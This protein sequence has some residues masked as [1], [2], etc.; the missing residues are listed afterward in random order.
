MAIQ[1][2][3]FGADNLTSKEYLHCPNMNKL[4]PIKLLL[5][6]TALGFLSGCASLVNDDTQDLTVKLWCKNKPLMA[7]CFAENDKGR[8]VFSAPG[9]VRVK[10]DYSALSISCKGQYVE[11]F[12]VTA[13][14]L[15]SLAMA[16]N[17]LLGGLVGAAVDVY[18]STGLKYPENID[19]SN[20]ACE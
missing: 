10:N 3:L 12:T 11:R 16:G 6:A 8:W 4:A 17:V 5:L 14:A 7:T 15:P 1:V 2:C 9:M 20:P 18:N 13:P 19:I